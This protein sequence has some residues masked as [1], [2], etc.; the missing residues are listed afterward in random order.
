MIST[1]AASSLIV[2]GLMFASW[3]APANA[4]SF[5]C[6][7]ARLPA[8]VAICQDGDLGVMDEGMANNYF[9]IRR[10]LP[11]EGRV[12]LKRGQNVFIARRNAC[13][14]NA[15]CISRLYMRRINSMCRL[16]DDYGYNCDEIDD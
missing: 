8:E 4:A 7:Y 3:Y 11:A 16:A 1:R 15:S 5:N 13:G 9:K 6:R 10:V 12:A 14:Y 2:S